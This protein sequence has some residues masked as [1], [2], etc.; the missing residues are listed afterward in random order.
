MPRD[1]RPGIP[2]E[3]G[4]ALFQFGEKLGRF[5]AIIALFSPN[6]LRESKLLLSRQ[7]SDPLQNLRFTHCRIL[8]SKGFPLKWCVNR[9]CGSQLLTVLRAYRD[10]DRNDI[11]G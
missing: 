11:L 8:L 7:R 10:F 4:R 2:F 6:L 9:K 1:G 5:T 3:L